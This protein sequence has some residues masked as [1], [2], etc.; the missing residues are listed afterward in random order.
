MKPN[1][2]EIEARI[3]EKMVERCKVGR[4][5]H[6]RHSWDRRIAKGRALRI[7]W[8]ARRGEHMTLNQAIYY[9]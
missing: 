1:L 4:I 8:R 9:A 2:A 7:V 6:S 3:F 5:D